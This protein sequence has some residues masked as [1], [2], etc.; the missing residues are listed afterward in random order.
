MKGKYTPTNSDLY[1]L[2]H[3][4]HHISKRTGKIKMR[5]TA[6]YKH[7]DEICNWITPHG[8]S[9]LKLD[10]DVVKHWERYHG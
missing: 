9:N 10:Y 4:V 1:L 2:V 5:V 8:P 7:N 6:F 3:K